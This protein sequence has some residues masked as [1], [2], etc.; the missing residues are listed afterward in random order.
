M[1]LEFWGTRRRTQ[2][3]WL[4]ARSME[5][6]EE[7]SGPGPVYD[8][9]PEKS[10]TFR[11]KRSFGELIR[12][13]PQKKSWTFRLKRSFGELW[14]V[15]LKIWGQFALASPTSNSGETSTPCPLRFTPVHFYNSTYASKRLSCCGATT[16]CVVPHLTADWWA[17][18]TIMTALNF[19]INV[20]A[21]VTNEKNY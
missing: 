10:W 4:E 19:T 21:T 2:K 9:S 20:T 7:G 14:A 15:F 18:V 8:S 13:L 6:T 3:A 16:D 11:L 12:L 5:F 17:A 1:W